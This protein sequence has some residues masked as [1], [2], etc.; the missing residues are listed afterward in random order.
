MIQSSLQE[1][2][3][4]VNMTYYVEGNY[5]ELWSESYGYIK[6][7]FNSHWTLSQ[8]HSE[9]RRYLVKWATREPIIM[10]IVNFKILNSKKTYHYYLSVK[11][12]LNKTI[13]I[14]KITIE[15]SLDHINT[16]RAFRSYSLNYTTKSNWPLTI[17]PKF[18]IKLNFILIGKRTNLC[19]T[20]MDEIPGGFCHPTLKLDKTTVL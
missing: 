4:M 10:I 11:A 8:I 18:S 6:V 9:I 15:A 5:C 13:S 16:Q 3:F 17:K 7:K 19:H 12:L 1:I 14:I 2:H 20:W